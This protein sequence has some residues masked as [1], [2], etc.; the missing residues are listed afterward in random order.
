MSTRR[1]YDDDEWLLL[2]RVPTMVGAVVAGAAWS[3]H[4]GTMRELA[5]GAR[6]L[7]TSARDHPANELIG[8]LFPDT[9][10][11]DIDETER[12]IEAG[13]DERGVTSSDD[14]VRATLTDTAEAVALVTE[15]GGAVEARDYAAFTQELGRTVAEAAKEGAVLGLGGQRVSPPEREVLA[16]IA[17]ALG[18]ADADAPPGDPQSGP[19]AVQ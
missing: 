8:E 10:E 11:W 2:H 3:G 12:R 9:D 1:D 19:G 6:A 15:R 16:A 17:A 13:L 5:A 18:L 14:F 4:L 7:R